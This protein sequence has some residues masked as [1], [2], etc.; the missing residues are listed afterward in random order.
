MGFGIV[1]LQGLGLFFALIL[2][3]LIGLGMGELVLAGERPLPRPEH[4]LDRGRRLRLGLRC[5]PTCSST[6]STS[7]TSRDSV[8][9]APFVVLGAG[10]A[11][12]VAYQRTQ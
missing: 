12:Y 1:L 3:C 9:R 7:A 6:A 5:S 2:G 4:R 10:I 11:G 8:A